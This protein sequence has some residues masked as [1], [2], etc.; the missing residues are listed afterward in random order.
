[1]EALGQTLN[2]SAGDEALH[3]CYEALL[4]HGKQLGYSPGVF[5]QFIKHLVGGQKELLDPNSDQFNK[6]LDA[7]QR[8]CD[9]LLSG[10]RTGTECAAEAAAEM[11]ATSV[12]QEQTNVPSAQSTNAPR[13]TPDIQ[14]VPTESPSLETAPGDMPLERRGEVA[15]G[16][17]EGVPVAERRIN[18]LRQAL[19][20][21]VHFLAV[22]AELGI[23]VAIWNLVRTLGG[24]GGFKRENTETCAALLASLTFPTIG[25]LFKKLRQS[26]AGYIE[27]DPKMG[28]MVD[29][30]Q[31]LFG[32]ILASLAL[33]TGVHVAS[34]LDENFTE[35]QH[36]DEWMF[37]GYP[38]TFFIMAITD[39]LVQRCL[40]GRPLFKLSGDSPSEGD[41][42]AELDGLVQ[43]LSTIINDPLVDAEWYVRLGDGV[44][45]VSGFMFSLSRF[46]NDG[47]WQFIGYRA[48]QAY[49]GAII[50]LPTP[51][52]KLDYNLKLEAALL[53]FFFSFRALLYIGAR[54]PKVDW[55]DVVNGVKF[56]CHNVGCRIH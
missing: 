46:V 7:V 9:I 14:S 12:G 19:I 51:D 20:F 35:G 49:A 30:A 26:L 24:D 1:M 18:G 44:Y 43:D 21:A 11:P 45:A 40:R 6:L 55:T 25:L 41:A 27:F 15:G 23:T 3:K 48:Y 54:V 42:L 50:P 52:N 16:D 5:N 47:V 2:L 22:S 28:R 36:F 32:S 8:A 33:F 38:V 31:W 4:F 39:V 56:L 29:F 10:G 34:T 37:I 13:V 17:P 53:S